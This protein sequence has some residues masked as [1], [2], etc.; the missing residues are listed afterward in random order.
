[1]LRILRN[2]LKKSLEKEPQNFSGL[3]TYFPPDV[4]EKFQPYFPSLAPAIPFPHCPYL[5]AVDMTQP[6][7]CSLGPALGTAWQP[8]SWE[9]EIGTTATSW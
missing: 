5:L 3:Q 2:S 1:M 4:N 8:L 9:L 7:T 6:L